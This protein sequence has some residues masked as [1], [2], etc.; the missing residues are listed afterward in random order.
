MP[1]RPAPRRGVLGPVAGVV[2]ALQAVEVA[3][4]LAG[5][6]SSLSG[7]LLLYDAAAARFDRMRLRRRPAC[8]GRLA[9]ATRRNVL[10]PELAPPACERGVTGRM[11]R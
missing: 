11:S 10:Q 6:G 9:L 8:A 7:T 4:E 2:G 5:V 1:C 3:K